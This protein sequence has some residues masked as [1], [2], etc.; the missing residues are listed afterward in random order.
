MLF[1]ILP[2][3]FNLYV[4]QITGD[5]ERVVRRN[6]STTG[7]IYYIH[8]ILEKEWESI[9]AEHQLF[10]VFKKAYILLHFV[11]PKEQV[12]LFKL[13]SND[14]YNNDSIGKYTSDRF[15][16]QNVLEEEDAL[17]PLL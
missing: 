4:N 12:R 5:H 9:G 6:R 8:Q 2:D 14:T 16:L 15:P 3:W 11:I 10:I 1:N 7:Q 17:S 13:C